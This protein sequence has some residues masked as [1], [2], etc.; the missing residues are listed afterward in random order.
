MGIKLKRADRMLYN[1]RYEMI[2]QDIIDVW[3]KVVS[4][5]DSFSTTSSILGSSV[6]IISYYLRR[7]DGNCS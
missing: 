3:A 7:L 6:C 1:I 4:D 5:L 2:R